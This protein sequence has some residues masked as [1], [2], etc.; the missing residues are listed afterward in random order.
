[1]MDCKK[2]NSREYSKKYYEENKDKW[3][4]YIVCDCGG[5]YCNN[6]RFNHMKS[7]KHILYLKDA[8]I[9]MLEKQLA[10]LKI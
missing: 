6:T 1:M 3:T 2:S 7:K 5:K 4:T 8:K 10:E 9:N